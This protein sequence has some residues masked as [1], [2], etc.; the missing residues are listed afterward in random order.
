MNYLIDK[1]DALCFW[2][3]KK[4]MYMQEMAENKLA[5]IN[6]R[7]EEYNSALV[8]FLI[9][10]AAVFIAWGLG[11]ALCYAHGGAHFRFVVKLKEGVFK[12]GCYKD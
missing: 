8:T 11:E 7:L 4:Y 12:L 10:L 3:F 1:K 2:G 9:I 6:S 5:K